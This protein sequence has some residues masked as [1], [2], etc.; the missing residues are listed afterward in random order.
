MQTTKL[1]V[2]TDNAKYSIIIGSGIANN[3]I[4]LIKNNSIREK[5]NHQI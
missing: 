5:Y 4:K 3:L 2:N 1:K